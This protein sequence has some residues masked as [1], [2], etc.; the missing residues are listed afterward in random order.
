MLPGMA[1]PQVAVRVAPLCGKLGRR[2]RLCPQELWERQE[3]AGSVLGVSVVPLVVGGE[4]VINGLRHHLAPSHPNS[5][6][7]CRE[8]GAA[9]GGRLPGAGV[10]ER[11]T[12]PHVVRA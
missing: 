10:E 11:H 7:D 4:E 12:Y 8:W 2:K 9:C 6:G 1:V 3:S 5:L